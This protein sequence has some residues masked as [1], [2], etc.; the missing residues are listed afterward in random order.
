MESTMRSKSA[1]K[2]WREGADD[3]AVRSR[4]LDAAF[5]AFMAG[6]YSETS[7][8]EVATR[9]QVS[10]RALYELFGS[11]QDMLTACIGERAKRFQL[12]ADFPAP[13][14]RETLSQLLTSFGT[15]LL[16]EVTDPTVIAVHRLAIAEVGRAPEVAQVLE[17]V[18]AGTSAAL[19]KIMSEA[20]AAGL[21]EGRPA[22]MAERFSG[23]LWGNLM[24]GLLLRVV[25]RP[26]P[27]DMQRRARE[28]TSAI[29]RLYA[30]RQ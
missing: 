12:P 21:L 1:V 19:N 20:R 2:E 27:R 18:R 6:G 10:K 14:D 11:K 15:K 24:V 23:L 26:N 30:S 3:A 29:V 25:E 4:I 17:S 28:A 9:A 8:L 22:E 7:T 13:V 16:Q 5:D